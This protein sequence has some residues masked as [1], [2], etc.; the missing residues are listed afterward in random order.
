M[1]DAFEAYPWPGNVRQLANVV[2]RLVVNVQQPTITAADLPAEILTGAIVPPVV[3][4]Q[5]RRC[6]TSLGLYRQMC[7][8]ASFWVVVYEPFVN[9]DLTR[10]DLLALIR[11]GLEQTR[12][13]Y[14]ALTRIFNVPPSEYKRFLAFLR[15]HRCLLPFRSFR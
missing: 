15:K 10:A 5:E 3:P 2:Q 8:G 1:D 4:Q 14:R 9:R 12:G 7:A 6:S 11:H 13:N